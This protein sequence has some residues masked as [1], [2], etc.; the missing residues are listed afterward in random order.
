M[1]IHSIARIWLILC[2]LPMAAQSQVIS[3]EWTAADAFAISLGKEKNYLVLAEK[4]A[5][6]FPDDKMKVRAAFRWITEFI[7]LDY[8]FINS[9]KELNKPDCLLSDPICAQQM[10]TWETG[11]LRKIMYSRKT[12]PEGYARLFQTI[13]NLMFIRCETIYGYARTRPYQIGN[14]IGANHYWNAVYLD[15][16]WYY[17]DPTWAAGYAEE[18]D[19]GRL[20]RYVKKLDE[21]YWLRKQDAFS[22]NHYP[23]KGF[24]VEEMRISKEQ[25]FNKPY[26]YSTDILSNLEEFSPA[27]GVLKCRK[28]DTI[29]FL[30]DYR[31]DIR[32][33]QVNTNIFRNPPV[34]VQQVKGR[35]ISWVKDEWAERKQVFWPFEKNGRTYSLNVVIQDLACYYI[36]LVLDGQP[37]IRYRVRVEPN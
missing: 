7:Q 22:R 30:F 29:H 36:E 15:N 14:S 19:D 6:Q 16:T 32:Q 25:F 34:M 24:A 31:K 2:W 1:K 13:C 11:F 4:I 33:I 35:K 3:T 26:Y 9:G 28:G 12:I 37:A 10:K 8:R 20:I 17:L 23:K 27:T 5:L 18:D 21:Y